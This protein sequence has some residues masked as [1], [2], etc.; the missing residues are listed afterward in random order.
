MVGAILDL[1]ICLAILVIF[2]EVR[3]FGF[4]PLSL[5]LSVPG[6]IA[7]LGASLSIAALVAVFRF[8]LGT[9]TVRGGDWCAALSRGSAL[10]SALPA[11]GLPLACALRCG[12]EFGKVVRD[13]RGIPG[14]PGTECEDVPCGRR[15]MW[16]ASLTAA[17]SRTRPLGGRRR[18]QRHCNCP[19]A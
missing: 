18:A 1:A 7:W 19:L 17:F 4:G 10:G 13:V 9:A 5:V 14:R 12:R 8:K 15:T 2:R 6:P 16:I 11:R 3:E